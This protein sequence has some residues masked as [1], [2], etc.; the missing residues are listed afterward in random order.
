MGNKCEEEGRVAR[1]MMNDHP[2]ISNVF[3]WV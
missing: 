3:V 2:Y 1:Y